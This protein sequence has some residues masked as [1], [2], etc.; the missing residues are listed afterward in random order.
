MADN[1]SLPVA[2]GNEIFANDDIAGVKYPRPKINW[3]PDGTA[4]DVDVASGKPLPIQHRVADGTAWTYGAGAVGAGSPRVTLGSD[5]PA[6]AV[7]GAQADAASATTSIKAA[8][9]AIA[10]AL[11]TTALDLG[12]GTGGSRTLRVAIDSAQLDGSEY[13]TVAASATNQAMGATGA[14][15]DYLREILVIPATTSP[16]NIQIKDG[17]G[18]A[19]TVFTGGASS[20]S[21]LVPFTISLGLTSTAG[22]WQIT[23]GA[24]VSAI[25][26]GNFT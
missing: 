24:N 18:T 22:A 21:N 14:T 15:G 16:G 8:L 25:G 1:S 13:E 26:I 19:I 10:T 9:R 12:Q 5:D 2:S 11:G 23:T 7:L 17:A 4:N 20:V 3:G 6:V